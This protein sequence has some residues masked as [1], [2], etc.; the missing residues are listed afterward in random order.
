MATDIY[1][2]ATRR[3]WSKTDRRIDGYFV[4]PQFGFA[5]KAGSG[6]SG[7][8]PLPPGK[9]GCRNFR[10]RTEPVM[11]RDEIGFSLDLDD[12]YDPTL[13][14]TRSLLRIHPDGGKPGT[15]GCVGILANVE[16][17]R[18]RL[19]ELFPNSQ[20][21]RWLEV[22]VVPSWKDMMLCTDWGCFMWG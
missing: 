7:L 15:E 16:K 3:G 19:L 8:S 2:V 9:Y 22:I 11:V 10:N 5:C 6:S 14:R 12:K 1:F 21:S 18:G 17:C 13:K 20:T 4:I